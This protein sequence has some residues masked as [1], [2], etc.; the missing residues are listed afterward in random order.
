MFDAF[1][2]RYGGARLLLPEIKGTAEDGAAAARDVVRLGLQGNVLVQAF[3]PEPL[4]AVRTVDPAICTALTST[5]QVEPTEAVALGVWAVLVNWANLDERYVTSMHGVGVKV[6]AYTVNDL[7][8]AERLIGYGVDGVIS[9]DPVLMRSIGKF[10][11]AGVTNVAVPPFVGTGWRPWASAGARTPAVIDRFVSFQGNASVGDGDFA[12]LYLPALR[13]PDEALAQRLTTTLK[14]V[15]TPMSGNATR[16][17]GLRFCWSTDDDRDLH[18]GPGTRGYYFAHR[19]N[20]TVELVRTADGAI[21][22]LATATW[23]P[24]VAGEEVPLL[25]SVTESVITVTRTDVGATVTASDATLQRG[26]FLS[27]Y[28]S[29]VVP[30]IGETTLTY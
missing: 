5:Q 7:T 24:L 8:T 11:P 28:G 16:H 26:G 6:I 4:R 27:A 1:L 29:G 18:G 21:T 14:V 30:G 10:T 20:G 22:I 9:D 2:A 17:L 15:A 23:P 13:L 25:V 19:L 12:H 3:Y